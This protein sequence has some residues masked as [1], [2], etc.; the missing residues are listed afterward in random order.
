M[1]SR[2]YNKRNLEI[3]TNFLLDYLNDLLI[4]RIE[5]KSFIVVLNFQFIVKVTIFKTFYITDL[6]TKTRA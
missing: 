4:I 2:A 1:E 3:M 5:L 6:K